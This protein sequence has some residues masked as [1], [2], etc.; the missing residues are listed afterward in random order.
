[1]KK[2]DKETKVGFY[3]CIFCAL[4][5]FAIILNIIY[6][7]QRN[8]IKYDFGIDDKRYYSNNCYKDD[9]ILMCEYKG[10]QLEVDWY[11]EI[12]N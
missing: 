5:I 3:F 1:M 10:K 4:I 7:Y 11:G 2:I 6:F 9:G 12:K 8:K